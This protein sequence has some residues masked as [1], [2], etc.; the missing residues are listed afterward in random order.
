MIR[1]RVVLSQKLRD[2]YAHLSPS[3]KHKIRA[4]L[5]FLEQEPLAGKTLERELAD[6]RSYPIPPYRI[7][8]KVEAPHHIVRITG[9]GHRREIYDVLAR[10]INAGEVR[11]RR[12]IYAYKR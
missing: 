4:S 6:F 5:R 11:E 7:V 3:V 12:A 8:Y 1:Y 9:I 2:S 10:K